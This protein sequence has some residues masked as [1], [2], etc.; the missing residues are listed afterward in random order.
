MSSQPLLQFKPKLPKL[1]KTEKVVLKLLVDAGKLIAPLY[2]EQ[3][4]Q[5]EHG[6][7]KEEMEKASQKDAS[8]LSPYTVV[9]KK[10][11]QITTT[12]YHIKYA[13]YLQ[14]IAKKLNEAADISENKQ[15][16]IFLRLQAKALLEGSYEDAIVAGIK[17]KPYIL[18]ISIIPV[19][20]LD[21]KLFYGK[22]SYQAW[23]GTIDVEGTK[24]LNNYKSILLSARREAI[25]PSERLDN[26]GKVKA[27]TI[28]IV[29]LSGLMARKKF[30]GVNLPMNLPIVEKYGSE[31][32]IFNQTNDLRIKEQILPIF[33]QIFPK[34]FREGFT[35]EDLRRGYLRTIS[36][37]EL[38]HSFLYYKNA[39]KHLQEF[40]LIIDELA[41]TVL[42]FRMA[43]SLILKERITSKQLESMLV[44]FI[45]RCIYS[46]E[47]DIN[48]Q[49]DYTYLRGNP[50]FVKYLFE[51]GALKKTG[52][53][54]TP[55]F[56]KIF[57]SL[58]DLSEI[59]ESLLASGSRSD[60]E[61]FIKKYV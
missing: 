27:K 39:E 22:A 31:I 4:K 51:S 46:L 34:E 6:L 7:S 60:A 8:I 53:T 17:L 49:S 38:A 29:L 15:F 11:G 12:P 44:T 41:A 25:I 1:S 61:F 18:D 58:H 42:G 47:N 26:N 40:F 28:D 32:T 36:M 57:L 24:R 30:V 3:E 48:K 14:P 16:G 5:A 13:K 43:G 21:D 59:L 2:L 37:H 10:N 19:E 45:S 52:T 55:N 54:V 56:M 9:E 20:H 50:I 23:I 33:N 35:L